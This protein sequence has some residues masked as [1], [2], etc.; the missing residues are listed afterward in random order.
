MRVFLLLVLAAAFVVYVPARASVCTDAS[1]SGWRLDHFF[2]DASLKR[3][4]R[5]LV[6]CDHPELPPR[7]VLG[8]KADG[9]E[10]KARI[11]NPEDGKREAGSSRD[12]VAF[13]DVKRAK[14]ICIRAGT[15]VQVE[16]APSTVA[17]ILL[18]GK[19]M[20]TAFAGQ[21]IRVRLDL[22]GRFVSGIVR[23]PHQVVLAG[24][25]PAW[26]QP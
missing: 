25:K 5:V 11:V 24:A 13:N 18:A 9:T 7:M 17:R 26:G 4:W 6:N 19:A 22:G 16:S 10:A 3:D 8:P 1:A 21:R 23:G 2:Y 20:Q 14:L 15:E 12:R